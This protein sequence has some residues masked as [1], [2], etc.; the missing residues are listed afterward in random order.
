MMRRIQD[1]FSPFVRCYMGAQAIVT[2]Y[3][4][5]N[6]PESTLASVASNENGS[7]L[8]WA[9]GLFGTI[10]LLDLLLNDWTPQSIRIFG[11][12]FALSWRRTWKHRH[13]L[14]VGIAACYAGQPYIADAYGQSIAVMM[15]CYLQAIANM[16]AAFL[17]AGERSR[18][19]WW[20]RT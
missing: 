14:F 18:R 4:A 15:V 1:Q 3:N 10:M 7:V 19:L 17:D 8:I 9:L 16:A 20:Q 2:W 11:R 6:N 13:F 12:R 5:T